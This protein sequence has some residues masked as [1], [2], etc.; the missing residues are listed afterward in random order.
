MPVK[1]LNSVSLEVSSAKLVKHE[2]KKNNK[3]FKKNLFIIET[4]NLKFKK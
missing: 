4:Y 1:K 3:I 2:I